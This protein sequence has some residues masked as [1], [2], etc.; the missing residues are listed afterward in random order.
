M[1]DSVLYLQ[2]LNIFDNPSPFSPLEPFCLAR[3][4]RSRE[5]YKRVVWTVEGQKCGWAFFSF[6][7]RRGQDEIDHRLA[8]GISDDYTIDSCSE[9]LVAW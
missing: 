1:R 7:E 6:G 4:K 8:L 2:Q 5:D 3:L 9:R